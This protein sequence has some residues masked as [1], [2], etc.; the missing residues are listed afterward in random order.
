MIGLVVGVDDQGVFIGEESGVRLEL[1][2][3]AIASGDDLFAVLGAEATIDLRTSGLGPKLRPSDVPDPASYLELDGSGVLGF[4]V[5]TNFGPLT[6]ESDAAFTANASGFDAIAT[7]RGRLDLPGL[8]DA[9]GDPLAIEFSGTATPGLITLEASTG[10]PDGAL[11]DGIAVENVQAAATITAAGV[12]GTIDG[13]VVLDGLDGVTVPF[14]VTF[15]DTGIS[16]SLATTR[17]AVTIGDNPV[18][19]DIASLD[20]TASID[21]T[22]SGSIGASATVSAASASLLPGNPAG[23]GTATGITGSISS[24]GTASLSATSITGTFGGVTLTALDVDI[25][26]GG[27]A[28]DPIIT[29][30]SVDGTD[31]LGNTVTVTN[32]RIFANGDVRL[33]GGCFSNEAGI[34]NSFGLAGMLPFDV[35]TACFRTDDDLGAVIDVTGTFDLSDV[36]FITGLTIGDQSEGDTFSFTVVA[37]SQDET[38]L[39]PHNLG[40]IVIDI[41]DDATPGIAVA[42][43]SATGQLTLDGYANGSLLPGFGGVLDVDGDMDGA[44]ITLDGQATVAGIL[45]LDEVTG[46]ATMRVDVLGTGSADFD[47]GLQIT[48]AIVDLTQVLTVE[49]VG[50]NL[51]ITIPPPVLNSAIVAGSLALPGLVDAADQPVVVDFSGAIAN[52]TATLTVT[53]ELPDG[54][55]LDGFAIADLT[56]TVTVT[57]GAVDGS[58]SG[59][60]QVDAI[61]GIDVPFQIDFDETQISGSLSTS[62]PAFTLGDAPVLLQASNI[63]VTLAATGTF[64]GSLTVSG[65]FDADNVGLL[66]GNANGEGTITNL[67]GT[68]RPDGS[69]TLTATRLDGTFRGYKIVATATEANDVTVELTADPNTP[70]VSIPS[71]SVI[72]TTTNTVITVTN[73]KIYADGRVTVDGGCVSNEAGIAASFGVA[74]VLPF[75]VDSACFRTDATLGTVIDV[76]GTFN[77]DLLND[78]LPFVTGLSIGEKTGADT[79]DFTVVADSQDETWLRPHGFGPITLTIDGVQVAGLTAGGSVTIAGYTNGQLVADAQGNNF[80]GSLAVAGTLADT[81]I[82]LDATV[83]VAGAIGFDQATST[84]SLDLA[85][86]LL[87]SGSIAD[88]VTVTDAEVTTTVGVDVTADGD[89]LTVAVRG[90]QLDSLDVTGQLAF[91]P[92]LDPATVSVSYDGAAWEFRA[93]ELSG[94]LA[95]LFGYSITDPVLRFDNDDQTPIVTVAELDGAVLDPDDPANPLLTVAVTDLVIFEDGA[96]TV[97]GAVVGSLDNLQRKLGLSDVLPFEVTGAKVELTTPNDLNSFTLTVAGSFDLSG[98]SDLEPSLSIGEGTDTCADFG[99]TDPDSFCFSV[100]VDSLR[101]GEIR[102]ENFGPINLG[103]DNIDFG[104]VQLGGSLQFDGYQNGEL[105]TGFG[106]SLSVAATNGDISASGEVAVSGAIVEPGRLRLDAAVSVSGAVDDLVE[107]ENA[108]LNFGVD[109]V[110]DL[111]ADTPLTVENPFVSGASVDRIAVHVGDIMTFEASGSIFPEPGVLLRVDADTGERVGV[112]FDQAEDGDAGSNPLAGWGGSVGGFEITDEFEVLLL[113]G[114]SIDVETNLGPAQQ[115]GA[116][117]LPEWFP[118]SIESVGISFANLPDLGDLDID[119][120]TT[121]RS[122]LAEALDPTGIRLRVSAGLVSS[123]AFPITAGVD[124]LEVD[125][126]LLND[127]LLT[128]ADRANGGNRPFGVFPITNLEGLEFG[129]EPFPLGPVTVG[130]V[131]GVGLVPDLAGGQPSFYGKVNGEFA[132]DGFGLGI[133]LVITD[134]GPLVAAIRAPLGIP[135]GPTG[136]LISGARGGLNFDGGSMPRVEVDCT[137][138]PDTGVGVTC[139]AGPLD[140]IDPAFD[141]KDVGLS[142]QE[143]RDAIERCGPISVQSALCSWTSGFTVTV[144][145]SI[146]HAAVGASISGNVTVGAN[147]VPGQQLQFLLQG[148][149]AVWGQDLGTAR[150]LMDLTSPVEPVV[151]AA[152]GIPAG[153]DMLGFLFPGQA[154]AGITIDYE[155]LTR[156]AGPGDARV[157]AAHGGRSGQPAVDLPRGV[158]RGHRRHRHPHRR[159]PRLAAGG[160]PARPEWR[161][162]RVG[163]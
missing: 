117:G 56:G 131:L 94:T 107:I 9:A 149:I 72:D 55:L 21:G 152:F 1:G 19:L 150:I 139:D 122:L 11:L 85:A 64:D 14:A 54:A 144:G 62:I 43:L 112:S 61:G 22:F 158:R 91:E 31:P 114:F 129:V 123:E 145:G 83:A 163:R 81:D 53:S 88:V 100:A 132:Y 98:L 80:T 25:E 34:A 49:Q 51:N 39:R 2:G 157:P 146:T 59:E 30:A 103:L 6:V 108:A 125:L 118:V 79:F 32:L 3:V 27:S 75:D 120:P 95:D 24:D 45:D 148:D 13:T 15:D 128:I 10:L 96:V 70:V 82:T 99:P 124:E 42:G 161:R 127:W 89:T 156:R 29:I 77:L 67:S 90:P 160:L 142:N 69:A 136:F 101:D 35:S 16:G 143:I 154:R 111:E 93:D 8:E 102:P 52:G 133:E 110:L 36:P 63:D 147:F 119:E 66:P 5:D 44:G 71:I 155:G 130:G 135:L 97:G 40:P 92:L 116:V 106:G 33:D 138:N 109:F 37:D 137:E 105:L 104:A 134:R 113:P 60:A 50:D 121:L 86:T 162:H 153:G 23:S 46:I 12:A 38:W 41:G 26:L 87:A 58:I 74:G 151:T 115:P 159:R 18:V 140:L 141:L 48:S 65:S 76:S 78:N 47:A 84:A 17:D 20:V 4:M 7:V 126:G 28:D 68:L 73:L 57:A